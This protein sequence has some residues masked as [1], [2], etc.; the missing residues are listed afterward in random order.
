MQNITGLDIVM[1]LA[2][3][4]TLREVG[5]GRRAPIQMAALLASGERP[6]SGPTAPACG[7]CLLWVDYPDVPRAAA[8]WDP[9]PVRQVEVEADHAAR[10]TV[11]S[12]TV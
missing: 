7:L 8:R 6:A 5:S 9:L 3:V 1:V 11:P 2:I 4:G 10:Y 12:S